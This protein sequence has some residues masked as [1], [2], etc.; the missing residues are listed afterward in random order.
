MQI[1]TMSC[2]RK[3]LNTQIIIMI[4]FMYHFSHLKII[5]IPILCKTKKVF[6]VAICRFLNNENEYPDLFLKKTM[7]ICQKIYI[8]KAEWSKN[9]QSDLSLNCQV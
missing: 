1:L 6:H 2:C 8:N 9:Y 4:K 3:Y 5:T 7:L